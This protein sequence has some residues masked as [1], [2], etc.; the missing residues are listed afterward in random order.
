MI[1][2]TGRK[3]YIG[4]ERIDTDSPYCSISCCIEEVDIDE[5]IDILNGRYKIDEDDYRIQFDTNILDDVLEEK[6][7]RKKRVN[8]KKLLINK[9]K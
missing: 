5:V 2:E 6:K 1:D 9:L 3:T 7:I 4:S 8:P